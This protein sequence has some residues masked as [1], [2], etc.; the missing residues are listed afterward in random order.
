MNLI[1]QYII[2][3]VSILLIILITIVHIKSESIEIMTNYVKETESER[4][5]TM[6]GGEDIR[7]YI[8]FSHHYLL[9]K[10]LEIITKA[11]DV[12][13][14]EYFLICGALIGYYRHNNSF[15]PWDD[16]ID[17]GV[18][19]GDRDR[20][21]LLLKTLSESNKLLS[22]ETNERYGIDKLTYKNVVRNSIQI[23]IFYFNKTNNTY[24]YNNDTSRRTWA[25]EYI[26]DAE[27]YPLK[28][29]DFK[30]YMPDGELYKTLSV[31]IP[32]QAETYLDHAYPN[33]RK[34]VVVSQPH[35]EYYRMIF[36]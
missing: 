2:Y 36:N 6:K 26:T 22:Y 18:K 9:F 10:L 29:V 5:K 28:S 3:A 27:L 15:V 23:D 19:E 14:I 1:Y 17:I 11:L 25:N 13:K 33:W 16:D 12:E 30:L 34:H 8:T 7:Y 21:L 20:V 32:A 24:F 35:A 4:H 31:K